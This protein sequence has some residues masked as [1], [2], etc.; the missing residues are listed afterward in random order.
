MA[1]GYYTDLYESAISPF[2][3]LG[4]LAFVVSLSLLV[5]GS[6]DSKRHKSDNETNN[7]SC[8]ILRRGEEID[9][10]EGA[11]RE[12]TIRE[13]KD[14]VVTLSKSYALT[15]SNKEPITPVTATTKPK[16][17]KIGF[18]KIRRMDIRQ[19]HITV[20]YTHLTLPTKA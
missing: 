14:V 6:A 17:A 19:G 5:Q 9:S 13:G 20:S 1:V 10:D 15:S 2:T 11:Q 18:Q 16:I 12:E 3:T 8:V 7:A 4:P